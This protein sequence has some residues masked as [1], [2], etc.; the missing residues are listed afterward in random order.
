VA[1]TAFRSDD[2][3][4]ISGLIWSLRSIGNFMGQSHD[5]LHLHNQAAERPIRRC[6][7]KWAELLKRR[8]NTTNPKAEPSATEE[9]TMRVG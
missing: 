8:S 6:W 1:R 2:D 3:K 9:G 7:F 4:S 5:L